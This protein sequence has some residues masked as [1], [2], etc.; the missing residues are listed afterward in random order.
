MFRIKFN[1]EIWTGEFF[2]T[3]KDLK[4][5]C[6]SIPAWGIESLDEQKKRVAKFFESKIK[7]YEELGLPVPVKFRNYAKKLKIEVL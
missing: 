1:G 6:D 2:L 5:L 3:P 7:F 4:K